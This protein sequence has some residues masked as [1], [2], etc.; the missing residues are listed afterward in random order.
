MSLVLI[1][2]E[3]VMRV[4]K[5]G[6]F[7]LYSASLICCLA[8]FLIIAGQNKIDFSCSINLELAC[9]CVCS[10]LSTRSI[11]LKLGIN[12]KNLFPFSANNN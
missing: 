5:S 3:S 2:A 1:I 11:G 6:L 12:H 9:S 8:K 4:D 10:P 7:L